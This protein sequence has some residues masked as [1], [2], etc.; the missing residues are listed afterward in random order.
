MSSTNIGSSHAF[1]FTRLQRKK[2]DVKV[3]V[4]AV[5]SFWKQVLLHA[6]HASE[7]VRLDL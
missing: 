2:Y 3:F 5:T 1:L 4:L 6:R 7:D